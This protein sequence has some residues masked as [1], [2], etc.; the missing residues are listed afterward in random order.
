MRDADHHV[1]EAFKWSE[2][3]RDRT[4]RQ[5]SI[6]A[7]GNP[8][9]HRQRAASIT[10]VEPPKEMPKPQ[11]PPLTAKLGKPDPIGER[12]LRGDFLMD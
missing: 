4:K 3:L 9:Q 1:G 11:S 2:A 7:S 12:M 8:L 5:P 6:S 10:A